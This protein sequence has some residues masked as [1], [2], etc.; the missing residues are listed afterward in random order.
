MFRLLQWAAICV[1]LGRAYQ[2]WFW[3][4][5]YRAVLWDEGWMRPIVEGLFGMSWKDYAA[6]VQ[7]DRAIQWGMKILGSFLA[8][9]ALIAAFPSRF[10]KRVWQV[11]VANSVLL[12]ILA[13]LYYKEQNYQLGQFIEYAL[14]VCA[15]YFFYKRLVKGEINLSRERF[16]RWAIAV[17][18]A[19][20]GLYAV[21]FYPR[22]GH[23][24]T[25]V[26]NAFGIPQDWANQL[27]WT[28]GILD[29]LAAVWI[30]LPFPGR[31]I[32]LWYCVIWGFL[33]SF[34]RVWVN[35]FPEFWTSSLHQWA[36]E[37]VYRAPHFLIPLALVVLSWGRKLK[38]HRQHLRKS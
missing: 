19:G 12:F 27:L 35:F 1:L 2:H 22:P 21:G 3:D 28:A 38:L 29:F 13:F 25:M 23:F 7:V 10:P 14:Q 9:G 17:T 6:S 16:I 20:H 11:L 32:A 30:L 26:I 8:L 18:F 5:P 37:F 31:A 4:A 34:A 24:T 36:F 33:T 15:P